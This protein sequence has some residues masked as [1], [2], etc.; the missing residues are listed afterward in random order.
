MILYK[1]YE[2]VFK[3]CYVNINRR[4]ICKKKCKIYMND[5]KVNFFFVIDLYLFFF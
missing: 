2:I 5:I 3:K 4:E 1:V